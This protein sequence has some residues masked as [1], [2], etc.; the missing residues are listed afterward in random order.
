MRLLE[1]TPVQSGGDRPSDRNRDISVA[2]WP[3]VIVILATLLPRE[4]RFYIGGLAF[5][6]DRVGLILVLP[7]ILKKLID[8]AISFVLPDIL[9]LFTGIWMTVSMIHNYGWDS[10]LASGGS[11]ALDSTAGYFLARITFRSLRD[12]RIALIVLAPAFLLVGTLVATESLSHHLIVR[13]AMASIFGDLPRFIGGE[14]TTGGIENSYRLGLL[15][16]YGPFVHPIV[17]GLYLASLLAIYT[18]SGLT[19]LP[20]LAGVVA[21]VTAIFTL[22]SAAIA[23]LG[24]TAFLM[25]YETIQRR[26]REITWPLLIVGMVGIWILLD[27]F[28]NNGAINVLIRVVSLDPATAYYRTLIWQYAGAAV[29]L[30]PWLGIGFEGYDR[31]IWMVSDSI[32]AHW[33]LLAVRFGL[34]AALAQGTAVVVAIWALASASAHAAGRDQLF[35]RG[36]AISLSVLAIMMFTVTLWGGTLG[37]FNMLLGGA[38]G[39]AQRWYRLPIA[40]FGPVHS[41]RSPK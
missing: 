31:P 7:Y 41:A 38:V 10:G 35:Y 18:F 26:S 2:V 4:I 6:A 12:V 14:A 11:L 13:P 40:S 9:M 17:G 23:G 28:S 30:H 36:V 29:W 21:A 19:R 27:L 39:C 1:K 33:L 25:A 5:Y 8:G 22:S 34:P 32:D 15:R 3:V 20:R 24:L 37:W 16:A